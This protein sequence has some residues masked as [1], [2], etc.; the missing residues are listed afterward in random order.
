M[1]VE[2]C[3]MIGIFHGPCIY[4]YI[5]M[6]EKEPHNYGEKDLVARVAV[7]LSVKYLTLI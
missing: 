4:I 3:V 6:E 1:L 5:Y 2:C 7:I